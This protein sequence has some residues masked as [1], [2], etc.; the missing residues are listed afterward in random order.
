[1][2]ASGVIAVVVG[3]DNMVDPFRIVVV[4]V[5]EVDDLFSGRLIATVN[6]VD[7]DLAVQF[8]TDADGVAA[9][10]ASTSKKSI[11]KK[12]ANVLSPFSSGSSQSHP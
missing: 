6:D 7:V 10:F 11:S 12:L 8:I 3:C 1:L 5:Y 2:Q 4:I 9:A